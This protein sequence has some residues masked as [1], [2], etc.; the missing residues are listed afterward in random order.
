MCQRCVLG[1]T[2]FSA[3]EVIPFEDLK[4]NEEVAVSVFG[5]YTVMAV[6]SDG[7]I[8]LADFASV[9]FVAKAL[10]AFAQSIV[11]QAMKLQ[12]VT[13]REGFILEREFYNAAL[14]LV[15]TGTRD[16]FFFAHLIFQ[17]SWPRML[18]K[19]PTRSVL[20]IMTSRMK[21]GMESSWDFLWTTSTWRNIW[22]AWV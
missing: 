12:E 1:L 17:A 22:R 19:S 6:L 8:L 20:A 18:W 15:L 3:F 16:I 14:E 13:E 21:S 2:V 10:T 4:D 9:S 7:G 5:F 11:K